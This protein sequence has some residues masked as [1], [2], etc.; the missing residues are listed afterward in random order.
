[1]F[2]QVLQLK[3]EGRESTFGNTEVKIF[4][5]MKLNKKVGT[6]RINADSHLPL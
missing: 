3:K 5:Y 2:L 4:F 6:S 1:M